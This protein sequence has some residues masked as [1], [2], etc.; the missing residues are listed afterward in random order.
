[1]GGSGK[2]G[3]FDVFVF[4]LVNVMFAGAVD[5]IVRIFVK[6]VKA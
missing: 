5:V 6:A 1:V 4:H 2:D 3:V